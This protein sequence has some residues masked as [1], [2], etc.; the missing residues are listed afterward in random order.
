M[1]VVRRT[2]DRANSSGEDIALVLLDNMIWPILLVTAI[3]TAILVP[4]TVTNIN[5]LVLVIFSSAGLGLLVLAESICLLSG[6]FD[7]SVGAIAGFSAMFTGL[8]LTRWGLISNPALGIVVILAVGGTIGAVNGLMVSKLDVNPFLQT[9]A[10]LIIFQGGVTT[11]STQP[12]SGLPADYLYIGGHAPTAI[13]ILLIAFLIASIIT[14]YTNFGQTV[15]AVGS[16]QGSARAVGIDTDKVIIIVYIISGL[17]AGLA[18]LML[19]GYTTVVSTDLAQNTVFQ[20]FAASII[21]G[22]SLFGGRGRISGALG[23]VLLLGL[24]QTVLTLSGAAASEVQMINGAILLF[25]ILLYT[26]R[27]RIRARIIS[28]SA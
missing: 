23:G 16:D 1:S 5:I 12:V 20:A 10:F 7:L 17:L 13:G 24:I 28:G 27:E 14:R 2:L 25:A 3:F 8:M 18:G 26:M 15:Y 11:L 9:L 4:Q 19:T 6:H 21:G 22:I